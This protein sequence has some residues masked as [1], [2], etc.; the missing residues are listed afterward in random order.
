MVK[1]QNTAAAVAEIAAPHTSNEFEDARVNVLGNDPNVIRIARAIMGAMVSSQELDE[2]E[3]VAN[4]GSMYD[5]VKDALI[6]NILS[7]DFTHLATL[8]S[9]VRKH[10][11]RAADELHIAQ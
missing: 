7:L 1:T 4:F 9:A 3:I 6:E 10:R 11:E 8:Q 5:I 2:V